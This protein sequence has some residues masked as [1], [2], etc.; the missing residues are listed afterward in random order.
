MKDFDQNSFLSDISSIDWDSILNCSKDKNTAV[1]NWSNVLSM[2]IEKH[3]PMRHRRVSEKHCPWITTQLKA[4]ARTRDSLRKSTV[5]AGSEILMT[6]YRQFRNVVSKQNKT[7]KRQYILEKIRRRE[8]DM[9]ETWT[10][11]NQL[12]NKQSKT[13]NISSLQEDYKILTSSDEIAE[14]M[15][16][17]FCSI[18]QKLSEKIPYAENPLLRGEFSLNK[19]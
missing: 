12:V 11:I 5:K 19:N 13:R 9:K 1:E 3:A 2:I 7:L 14:S 17:Y 16:Q 6:A 8:G 18:G 4:S 15:N 10:T